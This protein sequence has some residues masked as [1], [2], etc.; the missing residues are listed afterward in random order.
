MTTPSKI[1]SEYLIGEGMLTHP[2]LEQDWPVYVGCLPDA[3]GVDDDISAVF[4]SPGVLHGKQM[5]GVQ[6]QHYGI[7]MRFRSVYEQDG[8]D[9][10]Q[11]IVTALLAM[12]N[13]D[14]EIDVDEVWTLNSFT[15]ASDIIVI[16]VDEKVRT[17]QTVNLIVAYTRK[18]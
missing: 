9:K 10:A 11:E 1:I 13:E 3:D 15:Q 2:S 4:D 17:H 16:H 7:Q 14:V 5:D 18:V 6:R 8:Y 12:S